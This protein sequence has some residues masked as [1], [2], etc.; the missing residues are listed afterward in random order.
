[1][2]KL[3]K[4]EIIEIMEK[5]MSE[6]LVKEYRQI[7]LQIVGKPFRASSCCG[8]LTRLYTLCKNYSNKIKKQ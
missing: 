2:E 1:M 8:T 4:N 3:S 7:W 6:D 5:P